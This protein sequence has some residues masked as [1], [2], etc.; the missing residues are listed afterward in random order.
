[1]A[2]GHDVIH[3]TA[4]ALDG[5]AALICGP[6]G[7]GKSDLALRCLMQGPNP[8]VKGDVRLVTDDYAVIQAAE[9]AVILSA[10]ETIRDQLEVRGHGIVTV[11]ALDSAELV[12]IVELV[13]AEQVERLPDPRPQREIAGIALPVLRIAGFE[14]SAACKVLLE[15]A[16]IGCTNGKRDDLVL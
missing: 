7:S 8:L 4:I 6:S 13:S 15:L 9:G 16:Q 3:G 11:P 10:P 1:M 2:G 14:A 12:L 5:R